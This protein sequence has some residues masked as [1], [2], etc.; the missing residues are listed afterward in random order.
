MLRKLAR[1]SGLG[2]ASGRASLPLSVIGADVRIVGDIFTEGEMQID[3]Q[4]DG[5]ITC[6]RLVVGEGARINGTIRAQHLRIHGHLNGSVFA[7][8]V[9]IARSAEVI[10]DITHETVEIEAGARLEGRLIRKADA[11]APVQEAPLSAPQAQ[12]DDKARA[13]ADADNVAAHLAAQ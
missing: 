2:G 9:I 4:L 12:N 8:A 5:D 3:G 10:G 7:T 6:A 1:G 13:L 11:L